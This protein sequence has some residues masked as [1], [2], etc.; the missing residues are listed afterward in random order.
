MEFPLHVLRRSGQIGLSLVVIALTPMLIATGGPVAAQEI[1]N[2][3]FE[4]SDADGKP[5]SW[6][7]QARELTV[8]LD[9]SATTGDGRA[10]QVSGSGGSA[11]IQQKIALGES[12]FPGATLRG[13]IRTRDIAPSATFVAVLEGPDGRIFMDDMSDRVVAGDSEWQEYRIHI[14][15]SKEA[16]SLTVGALVI[17]SGTAWFD[18]LELVESRA[19][20]AAELDAHDYVIE[21]YSIMREHYLHA[22][23][24]D[25]ARIRELGLSAVPDNASTEQA[26]AAVS[27][28]L[29]A[30]DD[31]HTGFHRPRSRGNGSDQADT[32]N[33]QSDAI[34]PLAVEMAADGF[35]LIRVPAVPGSTGEDARAGFVDNAHRE[36]Q[37]ID[38]PDLCGWIIDLRDNT[39]GNMWPML[40]AI[41]AIA[42]PGVVGQFRD[43]EGNEITEWI[44][45]NG[46]AMASTDSET[47]ERVAG[48]GEPF[49]PSNPDL[50]VA[51]LVSGNTS[52]SGEAIAIAF[53]GREHTR[54]FGSGTGGL[55]TANNGYSLSDGA[56]IVLPI[57]YMGD[58]HGN[59]HYPRVQPDEDLP[60]DEALE[61]A[62]A[63]LQAQSACPE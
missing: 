32:G 3:S 10:L 27:M 12:G 61:H 55:A 59:I 2:G 7:V 8:D 47:M 54:L 41:G 48:F 45:R 26:H 17:G 16:R 23:D 36:L 58:R 24:V 34:E 29:E 57:G 28:M 35:A 25:W 62:M 30:L 14:P 51:V 49:Q 18:D 11:L 46:A 60:S 37:S 21:A 44:Y 43:A 4:Q 56:R 33:A 6:A 38:S 19:E 9:D 39:G 52:S 63:W 42:G 22:D 15:A 5:E 50:P 40:A 31:P 13:R 1:A 20:V 53:I